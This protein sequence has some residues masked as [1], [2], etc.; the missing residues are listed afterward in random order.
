MRGATGTKAVVCQQP[1]RKEG[2]RPHNRKERNSANHL[3]E[4]GG[5]PELQAEGGQERPW[6]EE[7]WDSVPGREDTARAKG[8]KK[9][10]CLWNAGTLEEAGWLEQHRPGGRQ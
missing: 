3:P 2:S 5:N 6:T 10:V 1:A 7:M 4:C 8:R 9:E